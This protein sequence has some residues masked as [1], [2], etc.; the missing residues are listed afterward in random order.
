V[1]SNRTLEEIEERHAKTFKNK[2]KHP[3]FEKLRERSKKELLKR[4]ISYKNKKKVH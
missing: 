2:K 3:A 1:L 4:N